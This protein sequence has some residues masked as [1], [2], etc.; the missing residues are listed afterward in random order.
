MKFTN[1]DSD[2]AAAEKYHGKVGMKGPS[3]EALPRKQAVF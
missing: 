2:P 1:V 3:K